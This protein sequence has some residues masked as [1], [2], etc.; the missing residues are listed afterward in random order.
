MPHSP[1]S[2]R[3]YLAGEAAAHAHTWSRITQ[4]YAGFNR[5]ELPAPTQDSVTV[6]HRR[7]AAMAPGEGNAY[8]RAS[9][10][11]AA[12]LWV[13]IESVHLLNGLGAVFTHVGKGT[14]R[15]GFEAEWRT[16]DI[17]TVDGD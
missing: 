4:A 3:R 7:V 10:E 15:D 5:G 12:E 6:D 17:M 11:L 13:H 9:W 14:S 16:V 1:N 8:F 2:T